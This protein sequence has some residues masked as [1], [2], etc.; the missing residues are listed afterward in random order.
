MKLLEKQKKL[1][2]LKQKRLQKQKLKKLRPLKLKQG[3]MHW[4]HKKNWKILKKR[5]LKRRHSVWKK[6]KK[7]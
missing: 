1:K 3:Q 6:K 4:R 7:N 5:G 2:K